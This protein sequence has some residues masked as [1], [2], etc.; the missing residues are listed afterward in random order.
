MGTQPKFFFDEVKTAE[1]LKQMVAR[2]K[3]EREIEYILNRI[4]KCRNMVKTEW[5][6]EKSQELKQIKRLFKDGNIPTVE[7]LT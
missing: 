3:P 7:K 5:Y 4:I 1:L 6:E 2:G